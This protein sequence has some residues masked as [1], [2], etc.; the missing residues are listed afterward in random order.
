M[1]EFRDQDSSIPA[2]PEE[3]EKVPRI[4]YGEEATTAPL[5]S[6]PLISTEVKSACWK[7]DDKVEFDK[8]EGKAFITEDRVVFECSTDPKFSAAIDA[9]CI[10]LHAHH[11]EDNT[12]YL[13]LQEI[14]GGNEDME[15][16]LE[17]PRPQDSL[18]FFE[19]LT[20]LVSMHPVDD[21]DE[22]MFGMAEEM[23]VS[24]DFAEPS[25]T[26]ADRQA[27]LDRLDE[28]LHVPPHLEKQ[29]EQPDDSQFEDGEGDEMLQVLPPAHS[30]KRPEPDDSQFEDGEGDDEFL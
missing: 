7:T 19:N 25:S 20:R 21:P 4:V 2:P 18:T 14:N 13:Q 1:P 27:M 17:L 16:T 5:L 29:P 8:A 12:V 26:E 3:D 15:L 22:N 9:E 23:V 6:N 30:R 11:D 24:S 10:Q 28:M